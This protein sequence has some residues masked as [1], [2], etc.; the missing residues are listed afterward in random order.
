MIHP[1]T[2]DSIFQCCYATLPVDL[3]KDAMFIPRSIRRVTVPSQLGTHASQRLFA[4][5]N[6]LSSSP[7]GSLFEGLVY[8]A[9]DDESVVAGEPQTATFEIEQF[10]LQRVT[11]AATTAQDAKA[12]HPPIHSKSRWELDINYT[13]PDGIRESMKIFLTQPELAFA[14]NVREVAYHHI[15]RA[16]EQL[17]AKADLVSQEVLRMDGCSHPGSR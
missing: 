9:G 11:Q 14:R 6:C 3:T 13:V 16:L 1:T 17:G 10:R 15:A 12:S 5:L 2:L 8:A 7:K 4:N